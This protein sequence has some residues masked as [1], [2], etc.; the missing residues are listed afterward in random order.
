MRISKIVSCSLALSLLSLATGSAAEGTVAEG[1]PTVPPAAKNATPSDAKASPKAAQPKASQPVAPAKTPSDR[2]AVGG[3]RPAAPQF[4]G[5]PSKPNLLFVIIDDAGSDSFTRWNPAGIELPQT[6]VIDSLC[7]NGVRFSNV[8]SMPQCSPSRVAMMTGRYPFRT[9]VMNACLQTAPPRSQASPYEFTLPRLLATAGYA[10]GYVG[11]FHLGDPALNPEGDSYANGLGYP[12]FDG[13]PLGGASP[14]DTT[15]AGQ[16]AAVPTGQAPVY[17]CGFPVDSATN[18]PA[19]CACGFPDQTWIDGMDA[20]ECLAVGGV[21]LV[22]ASGVPVTTGSAAAVAR[23]D[24]TRSNGYFVNERIVAAEGSAP[25]LTLDRKYAPTSDVDHALAWIGAQPAGTPWMCTVGF[26]NVHDPYQP[27]PAGLL[28]PDA[29]W[30]A[31]LPYICETQVGHEGTDTDPSKKGMTNQML[32]AT[33]REIGRLLVQGGFASWSGNGVTLTDP[34]TLVVVVGDNG[35]YGP[36]VRLP[37]NKFQA[38]GYVNQSGV[39]V[40]LVIAGAGVASPGRSVDAMV[41]VADLYQLFGEAAGVDVRATVPATHALDAKSMIGYLRDPN[42]PAV[43]AFNFTQNGTNLAF[44]GG[45]FR[46]CLLKSLQTCTDTI[47]PGETV[48]DLHGGTW[49]E[50]YA[51][52]C[53][54][55]DSGTAGTGWG[56]VSPSALAVTDGRYKLIVKELPGCDQGKVC[57]Y[58][59]YDLTTAPFANVL[60]GRGI[61]YPSANMLSDAATCA[62]SELT[63]EAELAFG[64][65]DAYARKLLASGAAVPGDGNLDGVVD[66]ADISGILTFWGGQSVYDF[67][68]DGTTNGD[69]LAEVLNGWT[70]RP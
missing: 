40:P 66:G 9:G 69:D 62:G 39:S 1:R 52:C 21:P 16:M 24:F 23:V 2:A 26:V 68:N 51:T 49:Y 15:L 58:E 67:N 64:A 50:G 63:P 42:A 33:D 30:P 35:S 10:S 54:L 25:V 20:V 47:F 5:T 36:V 41:N 60:G 4:R 57:A 27:A 34:N 31:G 46:A 12:L 61:D 53:D 37:Y 56:I 29:E 17:S 55:R 43:R 59:F 45:M 70:G 8:G 7:D 11:K 3:G 13:T 28:Q 44:P 6:P 32:S 18:A 19:V 38:K 65:L 14:I 22:D 48:C